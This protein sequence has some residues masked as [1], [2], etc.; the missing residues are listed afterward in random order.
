VTE[1]LPLVLVPGVLCTPRFFIAQI[2]SL[3][4]SGPVTIADHTRD[5]TMAAIVRR[6]LA[7]A[8]PRFALAGHSM[9]GYLAFEILRQA[10]ERV[11][12][13]ALLSTA[14]RADTPEQTERRVAQIALARSG[15]FGE[16]PDQ[17]YPMWVH[18]S[19]HGDTALREEIRR[20]A[21]DVGAEAFVRQLTA[22][23]ERPDS[24]PSLA[25]IACPTLV[26][27][28]E[29][30]VLTPP[31]RA[32]EIAGAIAGATLVTIP[33]CGHMCAMEAPEATTAAMV[34]WLRR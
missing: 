12:K 6:I 16:I 3:W 13:L 17:F 9:G 10:P 18:P 29:D 20:M 15:R 27:V 23:R 30:D 25:A 19:R 2:P 21:D 24:R 32:R 33:T 28:G 8:P 14:A 4:R 22:I 34:D 11:A 7:T 1:A 26:L 5:D 31:E